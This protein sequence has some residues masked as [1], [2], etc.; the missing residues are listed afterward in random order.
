[1]APFQSGLVASC[2]QGTFFEDVGHLADG[3]VAQQILEGTYEYPPDLDPATRL[4]F[5]EAAATYATLSPTEIATYVTPDD[6]QQF[7]QHTREHTGSSYSGLH[8]GHY[9]AAS[10]CPDLSLLHVA[11]LSICARNGVSL[12]CWGQGL[13]VLLEKIL[14]NVFVHKLRA[15]CL[16]EADFNWWNKLI[17]AKRMMQQAVQEGAI[18]Q[19]CFAKKHSHCNHAVLTK[20]F[21]CDSS[22]C[23]H[24]PA[25]L[26]ECDFGD[27]YDRAAHPPTSTVLQSWGIPKS[28]I[29]V[30]LSTMQTMQYVLKTRFGESIDSYGGTA[31]SPLTGLGQGSG[32]SPPAFMALSLLIVNAYRQ[33]G[34]GARI[35]LSYASRLFS[36][37]A[38]MYVDDTD[39]LHWPESPLTDPETLIHH[40]QTLTTDYGHLAQASGGILKEKK[41]SVYFLAYKF[42]RGRA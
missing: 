7:W 34:H 38:V 9:I 33:M 5:E 17:F 21:F 15:I 27:C 11:K 39:L 35:K 24:H 2:H 20:Q 1:M 26:R 32:A 3:P 31:L 40:V 37:C 12:A 41:C 19:E 28:A 36:L 18:P 16:L 10:F 13:T 8:F 23:P 4:L 22:R 25:G 29:R 6:F 42:V 30:L 14:G